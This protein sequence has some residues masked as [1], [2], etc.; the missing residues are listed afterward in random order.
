MHEHKHWYIRNT[1]SDNKV[2]KL[3]VVKVLHSSLLN[4]TVSPS[5]YSPWE[6]MPSPPNTTILELV[7]W[8]GLQ[9]CHRITPDVIG[10][11][12]M[13]SFQYFLYLLEQKKV[14]GG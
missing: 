12:K 14:I 2:R 7:L 10:V 6:A 1:W 8:K 13:P 4:I 3:I 9:T 11:I 5:K